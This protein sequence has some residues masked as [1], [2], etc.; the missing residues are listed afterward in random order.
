MENRQDQNNS[1]NQDKDFEKKPEQ[2][3]DQAKQR[4]EDGQ[5]DQRS[6]EQSDTTTQQR[7][8]VEGGE[9]TGPATDTGFV[10]SEGGTDSS[11]ELIEDDPD[12]SKDG[13][14]SIE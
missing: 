1:L 13:Q 11:G 4:P 10:G 9:A 2:S 12:F 8:D 7:N 3:T 5:A 6:S 14:G